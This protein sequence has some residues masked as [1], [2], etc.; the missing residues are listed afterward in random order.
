MKFFLTKAS[1][2]SLG[3]LVLKSFLIFVKYFLTINI[4]SIFSSFNFIKHN[5]GRK[6]QEKQNLGCSMHLMNNDEVDSG[7]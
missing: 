6:N 2:I 4:Q 7:T 1:Y 3:E 5:E